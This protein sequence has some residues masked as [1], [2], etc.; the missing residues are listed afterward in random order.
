MTRRAPPSGMSLPVVRPPEAAPAWIGVRAASLP[1]PL[2][3]PEG[4][5][6]GSVEDGYAEGMRR[7]E[8]TLLAERKRLGAAID[9]IAALREQ[10]TRDGEHQVVDLALAIA[11][12][13]VMRSV[14]SDRQ[15]AVRLAAASIEELGRGARLVLRVAPDDRAS[16]EEWIGA[17]PS[18]PS[19]PAPTLVED[20][21]LGPGEMIA[22]SDTGKVDARLETRI[23][24]IARALREGEAAP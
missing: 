5:T 14:E 23:S 8:R 12:E 20:P 22:E 18:D 2:V 6:P 3:R 11:R 21:G 24:Q 16:V 10:T 7:A 19:R 17:I 9:A 4:V 15:V 13:L 1:L